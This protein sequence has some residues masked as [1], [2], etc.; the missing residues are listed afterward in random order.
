MFGRGLDSIA[1]LSLIMLV[2]GS[3]VGLAAPASNNA[4][5]ELM[6]ERAATITGIRG[7]FRQAGGAVSVTISTLI[8]HRSGGFADGFHIIFL[9]LAIA[10]MATLPAILAM[11]RSPADDAPI[12][13]Q[14]QR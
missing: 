9:G 10:M 7:M 12:R 5:I 4:C 6:P 8:L 2:V 1:A 13:W 3:G 14:G 11:P